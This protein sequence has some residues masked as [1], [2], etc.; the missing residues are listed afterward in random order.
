MGDR[1][2]WRPERKQSGGYRSL[3]DVVHVVEVK[4]SDALSLGFQIW[5]MQIG[6]AGPVTFANN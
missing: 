5:N 3:L 6:L 1:E 2:T 4:D